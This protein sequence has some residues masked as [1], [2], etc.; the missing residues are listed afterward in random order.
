MTLGPRASL[1]VA[2]ALFSTG[3]AV[4]KAV[5]LSPWQVASF[6]SAVAAVVLP[7]LLPSAR[8]LRRP[9]VWAV[10]A[11]FAGMMI[12]Y[13]LANR[14]TT[15]AAAVFLQGTA[16]LYVLLLSPLLLK[17]RVRPADVLYLLAMGTGFALILLGGDRPSA[18]APDIATGN[19]LGAAAGF[20]WAVTLLGLRW[21]AR[22][23][24]RGTAEAAVTAGSVLA[25]LAALPF[26]LPVEGVRAVD[27]GGVLYLGGFQIAV[28][29]VLLTRGMKRVPVLEASLLLL[30][31][32]VLGPAWA[33]LLHGERPGPVT[34]AGCAVMLAATA[35]HA[36]AKERR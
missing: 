26:A 24:R 16:P 7:L 9:G 14:H 5:E 27:A 3:S 33:F 30:I 17:E 18:T 35:L 23:E 15:A 34:L 25:F 10:G 21:L 31:E 1:L 28:A 36:V 13:V 20:A 19:R 2:A 12:L 6:R 22:D 29:Y 11:A 4:V 32:P 8:G